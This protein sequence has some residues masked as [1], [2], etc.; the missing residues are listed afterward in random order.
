MIDVI[1][2]DKAKY[3]YDGEFPKGLP[4]EKAYVHAGMY[5]AWAIEHDLFSEELAK[6]F[7]DILVNLKNRTIAPGEA[8]GIFGEAL[9][10]DMFTVE[11]N[12]FTSD[13]FDFDSGKY[14]NDYELMLAA[15]L[16]NIYYVE[17][18]WANYDKIKSKIDQR[19]KQWKNARNI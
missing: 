3:H 18:T 7:A 13:Y 6:D 5:L 19:Y 11:G 9:V 15:H 4:L 17:D 14:L 12:A 1:V 2:Y 8:Y 10:S 16:P